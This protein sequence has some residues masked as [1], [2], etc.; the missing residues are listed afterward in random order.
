MFMVVWW[1][2]SA[3]EPWRT[4]IFFH[5][6]QF[7]LIQVL[8]F[9]KLVCCSFFINITTFTT[10]FIKHNLMCLFETNHTLYAINSLCISFETLLLHAHVL[11]VQILEGFWLSHLHITP[12]QSHSVLIS[13][14]PYILFYSATVSYFWL[15]F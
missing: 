15:S 14:L 6:R 3:T 10:D 2:V 8:K 5:C 11:L 12:I 4:R 9:G 1:N 7:Q 13:I